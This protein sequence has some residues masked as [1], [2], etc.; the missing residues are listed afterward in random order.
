MKTNTTK[1]VASVVTLVILSPFL[2]L[3]I[4]VSIK[5]VGIR[6]NDMLLL[7]LTLLSAVLS[8][9]NGFGRRT[10]TAVQLSPVKTELHGADPSTVS[11]MF[12]GSS[13]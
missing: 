2:A 1:N 11:V 3:S 13:K 10:A 5:T 9:I 12:A 4:L 6:N 7:M 8:G